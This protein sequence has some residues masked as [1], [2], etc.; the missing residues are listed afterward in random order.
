MAEPSSPV[1]VRFQSDF[2]GT[3]G[4]TSISDQSTYR[5]DPTFLGSAQISNLQAWF[6]STY[7]RFLSGGYEIGGILGIQLNQTDFFI[8]CFFKLDDVGA[9]DTVF[10]VGAETTDQKLIEVYYD[11][12][13]VLKFRV[14]LNGTSFLT[15]VTIATSANGSLWYYIAV[16]HY[17]GDFCVWQENLVDPFDKQ[18]GATATR[19][20]NSYDP[21]GTLHPSGSKLTFGV[22]GPALGNG[23]EGGLGATR[24]TIGEALYPTCPATIPLPILDFVLPSGSLTRRSSQI[25]IG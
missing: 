10:S 23:N 25:H 9:N 17:L 5:N 8:E 24:V 2:Q 1:F 6:G 4:D 7:G 12:F 16:Q 22:R 11:V 20:I 13:G 15:N 19:R 3:D 21:G 14:S 18:P